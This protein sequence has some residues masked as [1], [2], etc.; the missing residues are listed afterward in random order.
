MLNASE[1]LRKAKRILADRF[2]DK[3]AVTNAW[4]RKVSEGPV[5]KVND[6]EALLDLASDLESCEITLNVTERL[7]QINNEDK[8][9]KILQRVPLYIRSRWQKL[10]Q[11]IRRNERDPNIQDL[12]K[13]IEAVAKEK[14]DP[15]FGAI[16][17]PAGKAEYPKYTGNDLIKKPSNAPRR[18]SNFNTETTN[19]ASF[20]TQQVS[21]EI[22]D[23]DEQVMIEMPIVLSKSKLNIS[24]SGIA[25]QE[26]VDRWPH[27]LGIKEPTSSEFCQLLWIKVVF[28]IEMNKIAVR[29]N[30][31]LRKLMALPFLPHHEIPGMFARLRVQ[32]TTQPLREIV[33]YIK[34]QW[35]ESTIHPIKDWS[36]YGQPIKTNNDIEGIY[37]NT[38]T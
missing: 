17:E 5:I 22:M 19:D 36:I 7:N 28:E 9:I 25:K 3:Y 27:L 14:N 4:I 1:G 18:S 29:N 33:Q 20:T 10:V 8:M 32:A 15:V 24:T 38:T 21:L 12:R 2:G 37:Y 26:D 13:L 16:L 35:I 11:D 6:R 34:D 30:K 31:Y 23:P